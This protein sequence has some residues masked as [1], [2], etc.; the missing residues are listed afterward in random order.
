MDVQLVQLRLRTMYSCTS[1]SI[2]DNG[3]MSKIASQTL[4]FLV[5]LYILGFC[6][7]TLLNSYIFM[8]TV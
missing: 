6:E 5:V 3:V 1:K 4:S 2:A 8:I 7:C